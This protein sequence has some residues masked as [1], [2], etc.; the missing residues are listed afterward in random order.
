MERKKKVSYEHTRTWFIHEIAH[1]AGFTIQDVKIIMDTFI[2]IIFELVYQRIP[3]SFQELFTVNYSEIE[4]KNFHKVHGGTGDIKF[5]KL[6]MRASQRLRHMLYG[7]FDS[8]RVKDLKEL[9]N[10]EVSED[11]ETTE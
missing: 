5:T 6:N 3:F 7:N 2:Q 11:D 4:A 8:D 9:L 10:E 1:R